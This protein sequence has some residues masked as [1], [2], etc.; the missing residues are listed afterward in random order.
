MLPTAVFAAAPASVH[1]GQSFSLSLAD[2]RVPGHPEATAFTYSFDCG[3]G[4]GASAFGAA[5][6]TTCPT[7]AV[8]TRAVLGTV[9]DQDGDGQEYSGSVTVVFPF[10]GFSQPVDNAP[11][12][13]KAKAGSAIP[14]RFSLGGDKGSA[15]FKAEYPKFTYRA[16]DG[17]APDAIEATVAANASS[18]SY[19]AASGQYTY[20]WKTRAEY[21]GKCG[22]LELGLLDGSSHPAVFQFTK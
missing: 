20:V 11:T 18:L 22:T 5:S 13:N 12:P 8:G 10:A 9:R 6:S 19:S 21:A 2:A 17:T 1:V 4:A 16:C 14:V 15:I 7:S 3:D